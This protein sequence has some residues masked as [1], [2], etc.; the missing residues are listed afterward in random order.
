MAKNSR[1]PN[2]RAA[3]RHYFVD[4]GGDSTLFAS[5]GRVIIDTE[6]CSRFFML[7]L[8]DVADPVNL[9]QHLDDLRTH[10]L[11]DPYFKDVPSMQ[12]QAQKPRWLSTLKTTC[13]KCGVKCLPFCVEWRDCV[14]SLS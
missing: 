7:G 11:S 9:K 2:R 1:S 6:G 12:P 5:R 8:L 13:L 10:L 14:T 4:E 3:I